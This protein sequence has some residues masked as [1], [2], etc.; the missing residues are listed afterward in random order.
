MFQKVDEHIF[1]Q[2]FG[3]SEKCPAFVDL[4]ELFDETPQGTSGIKHEGVDT[5]VITSTTHHLAQR[6][7]DRGI[8][9]WIVEIHL[10]V[11]ANVS[12]GFPVGD[13]DDLLG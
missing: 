13:H 5:N 8:G 2:R 3:R 10:T 11:R 9:R 7:F 1:T 12:R 4:G 6:G